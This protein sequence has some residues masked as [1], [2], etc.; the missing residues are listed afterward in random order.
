MPIVKIDL[1]EGRDRDTKR[2]LIQN[3]SKAV[4]ESL[5]IPIEHVH[6]V[7]NDPSTDNWGLKGEQ[8]SRIK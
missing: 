6:V 2:K 8:V 5:E 7:L 3:V 1:Y 4:A